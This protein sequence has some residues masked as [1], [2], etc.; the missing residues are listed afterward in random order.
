MKLKK[1]GVETAVQVGE[2]V[3]NAKALYQDSLRIRD[4]IRTA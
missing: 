1:A 4:S 2:V 3:S